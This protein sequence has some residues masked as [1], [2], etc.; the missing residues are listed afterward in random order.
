MTTVEIATHDVNVQV[1]N[2]LSDL[3]PEVWTQDGD[4]AN[5]WHGPHGVIINSA[6]LEE[7]RAFFDVITQS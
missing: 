3:P 1:L 5:L 2:P 6:A 4:D 7:R